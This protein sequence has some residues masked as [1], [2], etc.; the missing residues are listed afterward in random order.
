[1][2]DSDK[3]NNGLKAT[4]PPI[5]KKSTYWKKLRHG[6]LLSAFSVV[7]ILILIEMGVRQFMPRPVRYIDPQVFVQN[8]PTLKWEMKPNQRSFTLDAPVATNSLGFREN[9]FAVKK[10]PGT[11]RI[12]CL[13]DS[14]T[15]GV[16]TRMEAVYPAMLEKILNDSSPDRRFEVINMGVIGYNM[17]QKLISLREK[18]IKFDPDLVIVGFTL[19]DIF[20]NEKALPG[21]PGF[22]PEPPV[23][24][25]RGHVNWAPRHHIPG[26]LRNVLR[27][28][29]TLYMTVQGMKALK[30]V[31]LPSR[32]PLNIH[33]RA[34]LARDDEYLKGSWRSTE[35][36]LRE[37]VELGGRHPFKVVLLI[38]PDQAQMD[39]RYV[40][41]HYQSEARVMADRIRV[42]YQ[43]LL[44]AFKKSH[45][46]GVLP[47]INYD[48]H[49]NEIGHEIAARELGA[50]LIA[51]QLIDV[52]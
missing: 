21:E 30:E 43:D 40:D 24:D 20:G 14:V 39:Q 49:P 6:L 41:I 36:R 1:M 52:H 37:M 7:F 17:R 51:N 12:L 32:H 9:E 4:V 11:F 16:G 23:V 47:L 33:Y 27:E 44:P 15:F 50:F 31:L 29:R 18:G 19:S 13:G 48:G 22:V 10:P 5:G 3:K 42:P 8:S 38:F 34:I 26:K 2:D 28:W 46:E 45:D 35:K 25:G